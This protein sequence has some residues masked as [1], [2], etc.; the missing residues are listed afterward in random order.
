MVSVL[1]V[2]KAESYVENETC[3]A[4]QGKRVEGE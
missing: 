3:V 2:E 1:T 4:R